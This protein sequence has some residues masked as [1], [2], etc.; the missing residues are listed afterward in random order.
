LGFASLPTLLEKSGSRRPRLAL[1]SMDSDFEALSRNPTDGSFVAL[2]F[3]LA[4]CRPPPAAHASQLTH[5]AGRPLRP[6]SVHPIYP[7]SRRTAYPDMV[8][9]KAGTNTFAKPVIRLYYACMVISTFHDERNQIVG[10]RPHQIRHHRDPTHVHPLLEDNG[11]HDRSCLNH[12]R[13]SVSGLRLLHLRDPA[14][15][16]VEGRDLS[17]RTPGQPNS[18]TVTRRGETIFPS[19]HAILFSCIGHLPCPAVT[20]LETLIELKFIN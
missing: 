9:V 11:A 4:A 12:A 5:R 16:R 6:H 14:L 2:A 7:R 13:V 20:R 10:E 17:S 19:S 3:Q 8:S 18:K 15:Q 1:A